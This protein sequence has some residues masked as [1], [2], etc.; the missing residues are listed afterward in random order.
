M[1]ALE[2]IQQIQELKP[3]LWA[4][5]MVNEAGLPLEFTNHRFLIDIY[6]DLSPL[7][8]VLKAPQIGA[9]TM[10][11]LKALWVASHLNKQIIYTLP[12]ATDMYEMVGGGFNRIISQ[13]RDLKNLVKDGDTMDHKIVGD[14]IIRFRGTFSAKQAMMVPSD[15]NI[16]DEVDAS[17]AQ[18]IEQYET[19]LQAK[20]GGWRWYFSHPT[21]PE[22]G[23]DIYWQQS[24][25]K[26]WF[27]KCPSCKAEQFLSWPESINQETETYQ[28]KHCKATL[29]DDDRRYGRWIKRYEDKPFSGYW[30]SQLICPW[31]PASK[32]VDDFK[33]KSAAYFYNYVLGLPYAVGESKLTQQQL[34][35]NLSGTTRIPDKDARVVIGIDTGNKID[36]VMGTEQDGLFF[37]GDTDNYQTLDKLM[38]KWPLAVAVIDAGGDLIGSMEFTER[39][40]GRVFRCNTSQ[41]LDGKDPIRWGEGEQQGFVYADR[42]KLI[43]LVVDEFRSL[44]IPL[45]GTESDWWEY[46]LDW[47]NLSR[48]KIFDDKGDQST[49]MFKGYK[50]I[51]NGRDHRALA[52]A[53]WR[54]GIDRFGSYSK[55]E[56]LTPKEK[57]GS[58][59]YEALGGSARFAL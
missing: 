32:I 24:D 5:G 54:V 58:V 35:A 46:W 8:V 3:S 11:V 59:G 26:H 4:E 57:I 34:F 9:T 31:I 7:Q 2:E 33:N 52:T 6:N 22:A 47:K 18:V 42:N 14:S 23:V 20:M 50:W 1:E 49:K 28:C 19:R 13:N 45:I 56:V 15:L 30:I 48:I 27:V 10:H 51:R 41:K 39:W 37:H 38:E 29:S 43:Q 53:Y 12:T 16:H 36:Y 55:G 17:D 44:R 25:Q 21:D 40:R